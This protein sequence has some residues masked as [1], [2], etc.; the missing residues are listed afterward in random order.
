MRG[1][2]DLGMPLHP[3]QPSARVLERGDLGAGGRAGDPEPGRCDD[4]RVAVRH[5]HRLLGGLARK[6]HGVGLDGGG[7][8]PELGDLGALHR[9]AER[10]GH[11]L[12]PVADAERRYPGVEERG[13]DA[14]GTLRVDT[15]RAARQDHR[16]RVLRQHL[17][18]R[19]PVWDDLA[20]DVRL[21]DAAGDQ[22]RVLRTEVDHQDGAGCVG[23]P[24][25]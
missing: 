4:D 5:P 16:R 13:V 24:T 3:E 18:D 10:L 9:A 20:V 1:V 21:A 12:E 15:G 19:H 6:E 23:S 25:G 2:H 11:R 8:A 17:G 7:R 14:R 22:L